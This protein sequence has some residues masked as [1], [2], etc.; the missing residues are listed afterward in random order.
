MSLFTELKRRNVFRV[1]IAYL[2]LAWPLT[3]VPRTVFPLLG[4]PEWDIRFLFVLLA[5]G[6]VPA[7]I[8]SRLYELTPDS[9]TGT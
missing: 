9:L 4:Y 2:A 3:E 5:P 8:F 6:F 7:L 1:A